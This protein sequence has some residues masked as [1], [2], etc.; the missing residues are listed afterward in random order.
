MSLDIETP[1]YLKKTYWWAYVQPWAI[2]FWDREWL[3]EL[4][5]WFNYKRL[6]DAALAAFGDELAGCTI[7]LS[8][9]YGTLT[10]RLY[11]KIE[12]FDGSLDVVDVVRPQ[13]ENLNHKL[14]QPNRVRLLNMD[15]SKLDLPNEGYDRVLLFFLLH[16]LPSDVRERVLDEAFRIV[17]P[18]GTVL[19]V[20]FS[21]PKWWHPLRYIYLPFLAILEPFAPDIWNHDDVTAWLPKRHADCLVKRELFFGNY[22][23][24]LLF[25]AST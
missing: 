10:P 11:E 3:I 18:G 19:I 2:K 17:K 8:C 16:E 20:E 24:V 7:Q 25:K 12:E 4:I 15:A 21:K 23:Q 13:L 1:D 5:L 14:S 9:T 6:R 22:Y